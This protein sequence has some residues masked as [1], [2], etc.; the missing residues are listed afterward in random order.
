MSRNSV[1]VQGSTGAA[2]GRWG[3]LDRDGFA[4]SRDALAILSSVVGLAVDTS[5]HLSLG[6]VNGDGNTNSADA[7]IVLS[8]AVGIDIPGQRVLLA[9]P[10]ACGSAVTSSVITTNVVYI[11]PSI[12]P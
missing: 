3:D 7:L 10:G 9:A 5:F 2:L 1:P 11:T 12:W 6:D 8:Y 4:N